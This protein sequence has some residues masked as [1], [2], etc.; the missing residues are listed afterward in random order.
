ML[1]QMAH[2]CWRLT[3]VSIAFNDYMNIA[4]PPRWDASPP[5]V[6]PSILSGYSNSSLVPIYTPGWREAL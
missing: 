4:S 5:Q 3:L 1:Y 2:V 6:T